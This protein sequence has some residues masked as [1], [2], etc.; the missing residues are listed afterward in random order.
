MK[1]L[2]LLPILFLIS[3]LVNSQGIISS[4]FEELWSSFNNQKIIE[5]KQYAGYKGTPYVFETDSAQV[6]L[7]ERKKIEGLTI[8]YNVY[9]DLWKLRRERGFIIY[10]KR[11]LFPK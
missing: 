6:F 9:N 4:G 7:D 3:P 8:R 10:Q 5:G 11:T 1:V 2:Y